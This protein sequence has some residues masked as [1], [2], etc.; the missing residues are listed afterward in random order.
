MKNGE[1]REAVDASIVD[2]ATKAKFWG[3]LVLR[4]ERALAVKRPLPGHLSNKGILTDFMDR[5]EIRAEARQREQTELYEPKSNLIDV[6]GDAPIL[7][8]EES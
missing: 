8:P 7:P 6:E 3:G 2:P 4:R 5:L 1:R